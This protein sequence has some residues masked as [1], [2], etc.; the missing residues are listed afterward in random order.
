MYSYRPP[1]IA[2]QKQNDQLELTYSTYVRTQDVTLKTCRRRWMIGR[3]GE[4]G[5]RISVLAARRDDDDDK[6]DC[7]PVSWKLAYP[8]SLINCHHHHHHHHHHHVMLLVRI[9]LTLTP[10]V[11]LVHCPREVFQ[12]TSSIGIELPYV[13]SSW[14]SYLCSSMWGGPLEYITYDFVRTSPAVF[15]MS[16]SSNFNSYRDCW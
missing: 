4:R 14:S 7:F 11:S 13:G 6:T 15:C 5:S 2:V 1:H 10:S 3:S 12:A 16:G 9:S 8:I